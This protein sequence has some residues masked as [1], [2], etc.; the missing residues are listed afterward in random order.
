MIRKIKNFIKIYV[1][2]PA[3]FVYISRFLK[4][5]NVKILDIGCGSDSFSLTKKYF[6][7]CEYYGLDKQYWHGHEDDYKKIDN[8]YKLDLDDPDWSKSIDKKFDLIIMSHLVEHVKDGIEVIRSASKLLDE[9]GIIY[10]E[11]PSPATL[12]FP[13]ANGFL[14]FYDDPT[15]LKVIFP[16]DIVKCLQDNSI[17]VLRSHRRFLKR[18]I[19]TV[20]IIAIL[21]NILWHLPFKRILKS[22]GLWDVLGVAWVTI[23]QNK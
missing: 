15:H 17:K 8:F 4:S 18:R 1:L 13:N 14:N 21:L 3:R 20:G 12:N 6:P 10:I 22:D 11:T 16:N 2:K 7:E 19:F 23:A 5:K 9:D